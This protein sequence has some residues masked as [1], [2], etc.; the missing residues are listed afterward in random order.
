MLYESLVS[1]M[2]YVIYK[3]K[4]Y[5]VKDGELD[6]SNINIKDINKIE[7]LEKLTNLREL[8]IA[9]NQIT[10]IKGLETLTN[11]QELDLKNNQINEIKGLKKLTN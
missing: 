8:Y 5:Y 10:E 4:N 9:G 3:G 7:D 6:L 11:L 1:K 2:S